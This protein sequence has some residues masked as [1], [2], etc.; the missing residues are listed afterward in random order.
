[1]NDNFDGIKRL[2]FENII[3]LIFIIVSIIN[4]CGNE[5][6]KKYLIYNDIKY[7]EG[8]NNL[9]LIGLILVF[10][11]YI[12]FFNRNYTMYNNKEN[13]T[14]TDLI[15]VIGSFLYIIGVLCLLYFQIN[16]QDNFILGEPV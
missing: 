3:N 1:M 6:E 7:E 10:L 15:K 8:A 12:Y 13:P 2:N 11:I 14:N 16:N 9:Y 4:I 5:L